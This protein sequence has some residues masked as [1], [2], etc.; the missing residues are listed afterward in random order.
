MRSAHL[1]LLAAALAC[2]CASAPPPTDDSAPASAGSGDQNTLTA[3][4]IASSQS[5]TLYDAI[6]KLRANYL[7]N[8]GR[9]T[10]NT[11]ASP[12]PVVY[13]DGSYYGDL[14]TLRN[15]QASEVE[16]ARM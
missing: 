3:Q 15:I 11:T 1:L 8:R 16:L 4:E 9:V 2:G 5:V 13:R 12:L 6:Q 7:T 14:S 10:I